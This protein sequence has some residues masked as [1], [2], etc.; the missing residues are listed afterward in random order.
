M[1]NTNTEQLYDYY[2]QQVAAGQGGRDI[3][4]RFE[5]AE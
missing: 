5:D 1:P 2:L 4:A 3:D